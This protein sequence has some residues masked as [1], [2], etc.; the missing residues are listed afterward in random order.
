MNKFIK[1]AVLIGSG[2]MAFASCQR[3]FQF[4]FAEN[5]PEMNVDCENQAYLGGSIEFSVNV[6]DKEYPLS[7]LKAHLFT[8]LDVEGGK[9]EPVASF[10]VR[11][12]EE[13]TYEGSLAVPY[14]INVSD[15]NMPVVFTSV[16]THLGYTYDTV[17]VAVSRPKYEYLTLKTDDGAE[18]RMEKKEVTSE[19]PLAS[20]NYW[21][22]YTGNFPAEC[23]AVIVAPE[24]QDVP[25]LTFGWSG[26]GIEVGAE[27]YIT[28]SNGIAGE[29][30]ITFNTYDLS[31][32]PFITLEINGVETE[33][34]A[35]DKYAAVVNLTQGSDIQIT[36]FAPGFEGWTID[37]DYLEMTDPAGTFR[38]LA[39]DG[40][41]KLI[42][43]TKNEFI[44][45]EAMKDMTN[46]ATLNSDGTGA[47]WLIGSDKVGKPTMAQGA[48]WSP[49]A[50]GLC[51]AQVAPKVHQITLVAGVQLSCD[52]VN[53]K[54][55]HQKTWG[56]EFGSSSLTSDSDTFYVNAG[57]SDNGNVFL[58]DGK[59]LEMG[60]IWR[61]TV[62]LT[63][64]DGTTGGVLRVE[65]IGKQEIEAENLTFAGVEM[66]MLSADL[67][68][69]AVALEKGQT[70]AVSGIDSPASWY[71]DPDYFAMDASGLKFNASTGNY[72]IKANTSLKYVVVNRLN[73]DGEDATLAEGALWL[74]GW[75]TAHPTMASQFGWTPGAAYCMA[76]V[77][78]GVYQMTGIAVEESDSETIGGRF[79]YDYLSFK[80]FHQNG[81][82][83]EKGQGTVVLTDEA[84]KWI[85]DA[86]N[87]ELADGVQLEKGAT[88]V[89][90]IDLSV[91]GTETVDFVKK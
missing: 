49:E 63:A 55:F 40:L 44:R 47:V 15:G 58:H 39:V 2:V 89:L 71:M 73:A 53:F 26:T 66:E 52:D 21:Y 56:G 43:E 46:L 28:F 64:Y 68:G 5:G 27:D 69:A 87:L 78:P 62:D 16:N 41:Y 91:S 72:Y 17:Y 57:S 84:S 48:S 33:M 85:K 88:Y 70:I 25:E 36:G 38:F 37:P 23:K 9:P 86:G 77:N 54:F 13:G 80:Y 6:S 76:E 24:Y 42:V 14:S 81:W 65:C 60:S 29:Y 11:T 50:G 79:R 32:G 3:E 51:L 45:V 61:F 82:G 10:E 7:V 18:Y 30:E 67:Y 19:E 22:G 20:D 34:V 75:G 74:M 4:E 8:D 83:G 31:A 90:T 59:T 35:T 1:I 12:K